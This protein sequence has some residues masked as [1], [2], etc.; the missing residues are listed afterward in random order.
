MRS[1]TTEVAGLFWHA[2]KHAQNVV[3][4]GGA[5]G[6]VAIAKP[7]ATM[8]DRSAWRRSLA[9]LRFTRQRSYSFV[10]GVPRD[11]QKASSCW[12]SFSEL[13]SASQPPSVDVANAEA[14]KITEMR[15]S[16]SDVQRDQKT[17]RQR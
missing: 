17:I 15:I 7:V 13:V 11:R 1:P 2:V 3:T 5:G 8:L 14:K 9:S 16:I 6:G 4:S 10:P 12:A